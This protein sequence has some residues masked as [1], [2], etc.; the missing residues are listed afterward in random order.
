MWFG[1]AFRAWLISVIACVV[2]LLLW[3]AGQQVL[4]GRLGHLMHNMLDVSVA[5]SAVFAVVAVAVYIPVFGV[6]S[7]LLR[8]RFGRIAAAIVGACLAPT[9]YLAIVWRSHE[10]ED[11]QTLSAWL[12]DWTRHL[13]EVAAGILPFA[14]AG[15]VFGLLWS[16]GRQGHTAT[17]RIER[18]V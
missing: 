9:S 16:N 11:P 17:R 7:A 14:I 6:L 5:F 3:V 8:E 18:T 2:L 12:A 13:P 15:I 10:A 1:R 4:H